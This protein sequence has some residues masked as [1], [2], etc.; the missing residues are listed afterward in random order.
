MKINSINSEYKSNQSFKALSI[1]P[2]ARALI[3][4]QKGGSERIAKYTKELANSKI[5][6]DITS[7]ASKQDIFPF[8]VNR[9]SKGAIVPLNV[10]DNFLMVSSASFIEGEK[11]IISFLK[12]HD[13]FRAQQ[14]YNNLNYYLTK[15]NKSIIDKLDWHVYATKLFDEAK[16][17]CWMDTSWEDFPNIEKSKKNVMSLVY[18]PQKKQKGFI[19]Y[20]MEWVKG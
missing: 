13:K 3:E 1:H 8:F 12:F 16:N 9:T 17:V 2:Q 10:K 7:S 5:W 11:D 15:P 14:V 4:A 18:G 19:Q 6:L 20:L